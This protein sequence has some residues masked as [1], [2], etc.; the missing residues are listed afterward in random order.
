MTKIK[1][2]KKGMAKKTLSMSLVVAMLAT[3]N[4]PVWAAE[5]SDGT[6]ATAVTSEA[7]TFSADEEIPEIEETTADIA[8]ESV[9]TVS[10]NNL[11][12]NAEIKYNASSIEVKTG[13]KTDTTHKYK[14][15]YV[16]N[17]SSNATPIKTFEAETDAKN[18]QEVKGTITDLDTDA[19]G[20]KLVVKVYEAE[21]NGDF[22]D[23]SATATY[24]IIGAKE[25]YYSTTEGKKVTITRASNTLTANVVG[26]VANTD[27]GA[28]LTYQWYKDDAVINSEIASTYELKA[29]DLGHK[30]AVKV[31]V[32]THADAYEP[33]DIA[34]SEPVIITSNEVADYVDASKVTA[35]ASTITW[36]TKTVNFDELFDVADDFAKVANVKV[37]KSV[38]IKK[39]GN[40]Y[41]LTGTAKD[42]D[43]VITPDITITVPG[44]TD[45][46]PVTISSN[47]SVKIADVKSIGIADQKWSGVDRGKMPEYKFDKNSTETYLPQLEEV[48]VNGKEYKVS[49]AGVTMEHKYYDTDNNEISSITK[50]GTYKVSVLVKASGINVTVEETFDVKAKTFTKDD[51]TWPSSLTYAPGSDFTTAVADATSVS[52]LEKLKTD[53]S[54]SDTA[55]YEVTVSNIDSVS[56]KVTVT[57]TGL[58]EY[59]GSSTV[60]TKEIKVAAYNIANAFVEKIDDQPYANGT[61]ITPKPVVRTSDKSDVAFEKDKDY[62]VAYRSNTEAGTTTV[63]IDGTGMCE[64]RKVVTFN[65]VSKSFPSAFSIAVDNALKNQS[66]TAKEICPLDVTTKV[67]NLEYLKD[68]STSYK[69][70]VDAGTATVTITGMGNYAGAT[71]TKTFEIAKADLS[72]ITTDIKVEDTT[73][74]QSLADDL[75]A[76]TVKPAVVAKYNGTT[77]REGTDY[78][79]TY[80]L[81]ESKGSR[82]IV[83][84][85]TAID[86]ANSNFKNSKTADGKVLSRDLS[87][88]TIPSIPSQVYN[89]KEY[90]LNGASNTNKIKLSDKKYFVDE[91]KDGKT[92]L[93][94]GTSSTPDADYYVVAYKNNK[95]VGTATVV[96]AGKGDYK[97]TVTVTFPIDAQEMNAKFCYKT[98]GTDFDGVPDIQYDYD[99]A[100]KADGIKHANDAFKVVLTADSGN[101]KKGDPVDSRYY[102][103]KYTENKAVG[104]ATIEAV[105]KNGYSLNAKTTFKITPKAV[106]LAEN[107]VTVDDANVYYTGE[108]QKPKVSFS[109]LKD[110]RYTL[111]E[112]TDYEISYTDNVA[113]GT[114]KAVIKG[115]GNY[116]IGT[117]AAKAAKNEGTEKEFTVKKAAIVN[118]SVTVKDVSYAGGAQ[119]KPDVT[120][121]NP[122]SGKE[123]VQGTD[124][125]ATLKG[126]NTTNVGTASVEIA[127]TSSGKDNYSIA[128][129][130]KMLFSFQITP[131][132][133]SKVDVAPIADQ[134]ATGEQI[135]PAV[136]VM[137]GSV[138]LTEGKDYEVSYGE[139]KEIGEGTV[140]IK[141]LSSNKNYTGSQ[142]VKFN[143]VKDAPVVGKTMISDVKVVGNKATVIL[144][145]DADG[146]SG[147]DYVI[148]TDKDCTTSKDY[149]AIS[150][151]QVKTSTAF[152]YVQKGTYYAYCHAWTRDKNGKKVFGEWSEGYEFKVKATTPAA[153]VITEVKVKGSTITVTYNKVSNVAGYDV[154]LGTSSKNDNGELRP[155][156]YGDHKILNI[157]KNTVTVQF[158][159]VP[160]KN[161]VVGM[162]SFTKDPDTNK[163]V[164]SRWSNLMPANMK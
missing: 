140:T 159:N 72:T 16:L 20:K 132:D 150:K 36:G 96:L 138:K 52:G 33:F 78:K 58:N 88:V 73:F 53:K 130:G 104:T 122:Y 49:D 66:Y 93:K 32:N 141:A 5:F 12:E 99:K 54:N 124:Y 40:P 156:R 111:V 121:V 8:K 75:A 103:L 126:D 164:F 71:L 114:A 109:S 100:Q 112:G 27:R 30:I 161:W 46:I 83:A 95:N 26:I 24:K 92:G 43:A 44:K 107:G 61:A 2:T 34:T 133:L 56:K 108:E 42:V 98:N 1:N 51:I 57:V 4:V 77:L 63:I 80:A 155:Y 128:G 3:S 97:G 23:P 29:A 110:G 35:N 6:D 127:L 136:T 67:G 139:N 129:S 146:A 28:E 117:D 15:E 55:A 82:E 90:T 59:S 84:T 81:T 18:A 134:A 106:T 50:P 70:N 60:F 153:P 14:L 151:N 65:I 101:L 135:K 13:Y 38:A 64:G 113:A 68:Y 69:N 10:V 11:S 7:E 25:E 123:L 17:D 74:S 39:D 37:N 9:P 76:G 143:I 22:T 105:G 45:A 48:W 87:T 47:V 116:V 149:D 85:L 160:K 102:T 163:K 118:N 152:K 157:N 89:E 145:G 91:I 158:K 19:I 144:S 125:T 31:L 115:L 94:L 162:R 79:V 148:S 21:K 120:V 131:Q 154:V 147:Y 119:V 41:T 142:T 137:N 86:A 62:T